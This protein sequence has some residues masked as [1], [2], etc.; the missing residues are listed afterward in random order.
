MCLYHIQSLVPFGDFFN[1]NEKLNQIDI[2]PMTW[3]QS[4]YAQI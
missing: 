1:F 2:T 4:Q 3:N